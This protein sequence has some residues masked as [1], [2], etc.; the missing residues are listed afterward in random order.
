MLLN[1]KYITPAVLWY[2]HYKTC[3]ILLAL[4][5][6]MSNVG[7]TLRR[8]GFLECAIQLPIAG[9]ARPTSTTTVPRSSSF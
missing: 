8:N 6:D 2:R 3:D 5:Y 1:I 4:I 9:C 7:V